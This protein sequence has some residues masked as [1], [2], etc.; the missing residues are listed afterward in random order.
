MAVMP[1]PVTQRQ[2]ADNVR[3]ELARRQ[4]SQVALAQA[5]GLTDLAI[6]RRLRGVVPFRA[7]EMAAVAAFLGVSVAELYRDAA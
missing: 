2:I 7:D 6:S 1:T 5:I 4:L 3:A